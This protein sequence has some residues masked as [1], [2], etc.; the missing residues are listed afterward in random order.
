MERWTT[1]GALLI[2]GSVM[3]NCTPAN[4]FLKMSCGTKNSEPGTD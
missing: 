3:S 2:V 1:L 4:G